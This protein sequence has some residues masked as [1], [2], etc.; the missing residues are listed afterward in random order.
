[1]APVKVTA[2]AN[3]IYDY[4]SIGVGYT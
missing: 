4:W 2:A 3:A 1:M